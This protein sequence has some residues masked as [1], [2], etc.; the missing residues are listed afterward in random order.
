MQTEDRKLDEGR[1]SDYKKGHGMLAELEGNGMLEVGRSECET[2][3]GEGIHL[4]CTTVTISPRKRPGRNKGVGLLRLNGYA[5][6]G[7]E[8]FFVESSEHPGHPVTLKGDL[9]QAAERCFN[10][11][12][13]AR[14][15]RGQPGWADVQ[16]QIKE[17][18]L[19]GSR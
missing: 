6:E 11:C 9:R 19:A 8:I 14:N 2:T 3:V 18:V 16:F 17:L 1:E 7:G 10:T 5:K 15:L 4:I 12:R 13:D